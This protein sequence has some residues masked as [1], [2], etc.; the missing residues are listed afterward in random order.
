MRICEDDTYIGDF[1]VSGESS[2]GEHVLWLTAMP[3]IYYWV[4]ENYRRDLD[5]GAGYHLNQSNRLLHEIDRGDSLWAF[6]R[7]TT[8]RYV[9]AAE[10]VVRAKTTNP[11]GYR[12]GAYRLWGDLRRSRYF[13]TEGQPDVSELIRGLSVRAGATVLGRSFQG[14]AAVRQLTPAD[15][16]ALAEYAWRLSRDPRA[17]LLPEEELEARI[18]HGDQDAVSRLIT[19]EAPGIADKRRRYLFSQAQRRNRQHVGKL[20]ELY[21]G[22]C[23][24]CGWNPTSVY[25][26]ELCEAHHVHWLSRGG[27]DDLHNLVLICPNHHRAI[28]RTD[29][30]FDWEDS[31][32]VFPRNRERVK[33]Y[34]HA[35]EAR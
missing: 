29:A 8:G 1:A 22:M 11:S 27:D 23:Q 10:L 32:F 15:H 9:L 31:S 18:L 2:G 3:L 25:R 19:T 26:Q 13:R 7:T 4:G 14:H 12:Y 35:L 28:H 33:I 5:W 17:R 6:T 20:R 30:P 16:Q 34:R 24:L 21:G